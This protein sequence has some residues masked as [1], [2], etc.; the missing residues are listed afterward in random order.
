MLSPIG[1]QG[2][3]LAPVFV[4]IT[5][6]SSS[7]PRLCLPEE[8][9]HL[10]LGISQHIHQLRSH[11]TI[12]FSVEEACRLPGISHSPSATYAMNVLIHVI[13]HIVVNNMGHARDI[14]TTSC[15][16]RGHKDRLFSSPEVE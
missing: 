9:R 10:H 3:N 13:R 8:V 15:H 2:R 6:G 1:Q 12:P 5:T 11:V 4:V 16:S 7:T 14:Q